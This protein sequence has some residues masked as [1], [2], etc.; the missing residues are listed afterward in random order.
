MITLMSWGI[1]YGE[2][3]A[4]FKFDV[5]YLR[6]P[7]R[8]KQKLKGYLSMKDAV[9]AFMEQQKEFGILALKFANLIDIIN[10][11]FPDE[12]LVFCFFC[13][14]GEYRSPA[15]VEKISEELGKRGIVFRKLANVNSK[16]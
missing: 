14:A 12:N 9:M 6:N 1:K 10:S 5:S 7:W 13:S 11:Q 3:P 15:M 4:N 16:L 8:D 2:P